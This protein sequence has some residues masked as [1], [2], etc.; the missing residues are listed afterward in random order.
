MQACFH[1][2]LSSRRGEHRRKLYERQDAWRLAPPGTPEAKMPG[3]LDPSATRVRLKEAQEE[4]ARAQAAAAQE[5]FERALLH[6][7][8]EVKKLKLEHELWCFEQKYSLNQPRDE[9]G[10]WTSGASSVGVA[11]AADSSDSGAPSGGDAQVAELGGSNDTISDASTAPFSS[12][13]SGWHDYKVGPNL[14][15]GAELQ[16][17]REEMTDQLARFS[18]PGREP[19]LTV[20]QDQRMY[21]VH[22]P[23]TDIY[24]GD[25]KTRIIDGGLTIENRTEQGHIFFD[26]VV[27][28]R[29]IQSDDGDW[30]VT[31]HG[32]GNNVYPGANAANQLVG[33]DVFNE[34][35][36][37]MRANIERHHAKGALLD[38]AIHRMDGRGR[39]SPR[40]A[41]LGAR[42]EIA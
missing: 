29:L 21:P 18:L 35:D 15:C 12:D 20:L 10:R 42:H 41:I 1:D 33:P 36:R 8:W 9:Q 38:L 5:E 3:W 19:F 26:G 37:Q 14:V 34:L 28:R 16:C 17:T 27:I 23:G 6:L 32:F 2:L 30:Y 4:D 24:V 25:V 13:K 40:P 7:R 22:I 31:T 11:A 39:Y